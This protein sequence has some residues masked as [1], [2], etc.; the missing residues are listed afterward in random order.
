VSSSL[1]LRNE[2]K[3]EIPLDILATQFDRAKGVLHP[4]RKAADRTS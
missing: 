3:W 1:N 4:G 2:A